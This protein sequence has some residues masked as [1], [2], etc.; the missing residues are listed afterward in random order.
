MNSPDLTATIDLAAIAHNVG[1]LRDTSGA[2]VLAVVKADA[3]GHGA[4]PVA[5]TMLAAGAAGLGVARLPEALVLR[6]SGID[7]PITAWLHTGSTDFAAGVAAGIDIAVSSPRQ[8]DAVVAAARAVG[9]TATVTIKVDTGLRRSG[10]AVE[11]W[12]DFVDVCAKALA[13]NSIRLQGMMTHLA[14]GDEPSNP[15]NS[16]QA[17][18]LDAAVA[19]LARLGI[20]PQAVHISNSP[21]ALSRRDLSRD[22]VRPGIA[23]YGRTPLPAIGDFGLIP[24]MTLSAEVALVKKV[25]TGEGVSYGQTWIAQRDSMIAVI[26]AGYA[27]GVPRTLSGQLRVFINGQPFAGVGRVCMDQFVVDLGPDGGGVVEG[28]RAVLFGTGADGGPTARE[29]ADATGTI[30]YEIVSG[31]GTRVVRQYVGGARSEVIDD[32][33]A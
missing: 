13:D 27:D 18:E 9:T 14:C 28:D 4:V 17:A 33:R 24:A 32:G 5:R 30:D 8:L 2:D 22:I 25:R 29:W 10:V 1:V 15:L 31:I 19:D 7:A 12:S 23:L 21:A 26:P 3:Y 20:T 6:E 11:E 16:A